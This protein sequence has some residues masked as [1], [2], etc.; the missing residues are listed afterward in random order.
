MSVV[1]HYELD[2]I[3]PFL[4]L[5]TNG[6]LERDTLAL[7][8]LFLEYVDL[9]RMLLEAE[10]D[11]DME[12]LKDI[13]AHF[14]AMTANLIQCVPG[15]EEKLFDKLEKLIRKSQSC[16]YSFTFM[17]FNTHMMLFLQWDTKVYFQKHNEQAIRH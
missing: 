1:V 11:K 14:S 15:K 13:R 17:S 7:G 9:T 16:L 8:A 4:S 3:S 12:I 2:S 5:S 6:A 10:N